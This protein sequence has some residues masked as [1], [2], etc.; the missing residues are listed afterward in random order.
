M[1]I[2][3][4]YPSDCTQLLGLMSELADFSAQRES[5]AGTRQ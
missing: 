3:A 4:A 5:F 2:R 1:I